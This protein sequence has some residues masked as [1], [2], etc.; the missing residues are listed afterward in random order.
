MTL[1]TIVR[2]NHDVEVAASKAQAIEAALETSSKIFELV[3]AKGS[4]SQYGF[5]RFWRNTRVH[6]L[7]DPIAYKFREV[8]SWALLGEAPEPSWYT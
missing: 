1:S 7:H 2:S 5:D 8:G 3:G 6:S 4:L